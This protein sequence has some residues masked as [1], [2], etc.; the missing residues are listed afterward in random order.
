V[1]D[2]A[3]VPAEWTATIPA[4]RAASYDEVG[5]VIAFLASDD[6]AYITG[7]NLKVDGGFTRSV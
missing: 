3:A 4:G 7:E 6:A 2:P 5:R 1:A